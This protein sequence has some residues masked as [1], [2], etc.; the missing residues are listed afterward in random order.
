MGGPATNTIGNVSL[1]MV[2]NLTLSPTSV[3][4][5]T[6]AEQTFTVPGL[7]LGDY[8]NAN[9]SGAPQAGLTI[10]NTRATAN[11]TIGITFGNLTAATI[12][13]TAS[14][15][16]TVFVARYENYGE[17]ASAPSGISA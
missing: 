15:V 4:P 13:P 7:H 6:S 9:N 3:A 8:V 14:S 17:S 16:Y 2:L 5:N 10:T 1:V 12:T 11:G